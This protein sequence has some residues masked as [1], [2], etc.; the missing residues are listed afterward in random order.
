MFAVFK[1]GGKEYKAEL[2]ESLHIEKVEGNEGDT[3]SIDE[4]LLIKDDKE[5]TI[6]APT[7][8]KTT[9]EAKIINQYRGDKIIIFKHK[10]RK[11]Y[12]KKTGHRQS[13]TEVVIT[14]IANTTLKDAVKKETKKEDLPK[15][16]NE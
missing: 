10:R 9:V 8:A 5:T 4:V 14:K 13:L 7:I 12:R 11:T 1:T 3:V 2:G 15:A 16:V 6:G